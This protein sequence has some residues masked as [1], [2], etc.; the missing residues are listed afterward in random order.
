MLR[1]LRLKIFRARSLIKQD[2]IFYA[3][4]KFVHMVRSVGF[5]QFFFIFEY[6]RLIIRSLKFNALVRFWE[7]HLIFCI[8]WAWNLWCLSWFKFF[9]LPTLER[10]YFFSIR[11]YPR[12]KHLVL[13]LFNIFIDLLYPKGEIVRNFRVF[14]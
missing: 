11:N 6:L 1:L 13:L 5:F 8:P 14:L 4:T 12:P 9:L 3:M 2:K 7:I 10:F